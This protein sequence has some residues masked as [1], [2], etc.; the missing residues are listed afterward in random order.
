MRTVKKWATVSGV[1]AAGCL[2]LDRLD[3]TADTIGLS[4][5]LI[6]ATA[7]LAL[8]LT[9]FVLTPIAG[10]LGRAGARAIDGW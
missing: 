7:G 10:A 1:V 3:L 4:G 8:V 5:I 6:V 2:A 9:A